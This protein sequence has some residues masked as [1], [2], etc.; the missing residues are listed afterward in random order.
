[1]QLRKF[2]MILL[3]LPLINLSGCSI[4]KP[5]IVTETKFIYPNIINPNNPKPVFLNDVEFKVITDET[6]LEFKEAII[7]GNG[8]FVF[9]GIEIKDYENMAL[10]IGELRRYIIQQKAIILYY[11]KTVDSFKPEEINAEPDKKTG[12]LK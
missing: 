3:I 1:M 9:I 7:K 2:L 10:N 11:K 12:D 6:Y 4:F 8:E 5:K